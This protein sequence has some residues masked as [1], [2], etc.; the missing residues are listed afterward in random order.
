MPIYDGFVMAETRDE[1]E[2][3][4]GRHS[5][6]VYVPSTRGLLLKLRSGP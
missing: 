1:R 3:Q 6:V 2:R 5:L 4:R